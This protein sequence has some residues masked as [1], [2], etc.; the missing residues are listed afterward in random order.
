MVRFLAAL[1]SLTFTASAD[2]KVG[3]PAPEISPA[4]LL[5]DQPAANANLR[6]LKGKAVV[7]EFWATWCGPCVM[8]IPHLNEL[9]VQFQDKP[10]VFL[11]VTDENRAVVE[12]FLKKRPIEGW[13]GL[14]RD[15]KTFADYGVTGVPRTFLI[16][17]CRQTGRGCHTGRFDRR[18][19]R[20]SAGATADQRPHDHLRIVGDP[21]E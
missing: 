17:R 14:A 8:A 9:T 5:P 10:V 13:V 2:V 18:I 1:L 7:L 21:A 11:S 3:Q 16:G 12:P 6:A 19:D 4:Q 15:R 20:R